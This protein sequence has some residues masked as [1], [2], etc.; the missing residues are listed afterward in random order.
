MMIKVS[1]IRKEY[2][3]KGAF[4]KQG[5]ASKRDGNLTPYVDFQL[6]LELLNRGNDDNI[7]SIAHTTESVAYHCT[8]WHGIV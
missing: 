8:A 5:G 4:Y 2:W 3:G 6:H 7:Y 1:V